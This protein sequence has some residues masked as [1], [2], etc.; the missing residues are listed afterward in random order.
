MF[1]PL[2][3]GITALSLTLATTT[4]LHAQGMNRDDVGKLIFGL[5]A[6]AV[7]GA[8]IDQNRDRDRDRR[9][10][11]HQTPQWNDAHRNNTW[12]DLNR[13][14]QNTQN[15]RRALPHAC[16]R[17]VETRFG[18]QGLFGKQC[19]ERNYRHVNRLPDRCAV[20]IYTNDG[21]RRGFDPLCLREQGFRSDRRH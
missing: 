9:T 7:I 8:A 18:H 4:P 20:R 1:K 21:P 13:E 19:L 14:H 12:S 5:A 15:S 17:T 6:I 3:A 16:L 11:V 2:I 10:Q